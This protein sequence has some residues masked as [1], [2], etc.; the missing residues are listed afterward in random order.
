MYP[1]PFLPLSP[2]FVAMSIVEYVLVPTQSY[3][4]SSTTRHNYLQV[5]LYDK[6]FFGHQHT[7]SIRIRKVFFLISLPRKRKTVYSRELPI[8]FAGCF[9]ASRLFFLLPSTST[10][11]AYCSVK[12]LSYNYTRNKR[13]KLLFHY[14]KVHFMEERKEFCVNNR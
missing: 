10:Y 7:Y 4:I 8:I 2:P 14:G 1:P 9:F 13:E 12:P 5:R 11:C 3:T 6:C